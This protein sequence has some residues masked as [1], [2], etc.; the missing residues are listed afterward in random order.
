[1][2]LKVDMKIDGLRSEMN[3]KIDG[4]RSEMNARFEAIDKRFD[5]LLVS[6]GP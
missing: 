3:G 2:K 5:Q 1:M 6:C 4:L